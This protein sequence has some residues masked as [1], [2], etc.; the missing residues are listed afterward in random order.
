MGKKIRW[1]ATGVL[2]L[3]FL[4]STGVIL[5]TRHQYRVSEELY[6]RASNRYTVR[7]EELKTQ[8]GDAL[9]PVVVDFDLLRA[10]N[11]DIVG[12]I[13]CEGTPLDYLVVQGPDN[14]YYLRRSY[15]GVHSTAGTIFIDA[16]N[17]PD[18]ADCNTIIYGH[19]MKNGSMFAV[20]SD[21]AEQEFY[22]EHPV[23]W[24]LTPEQDYQ[25]VLKS[26]YTVSAHSDTYTIYP[27]ACEEFD[28]YLADAM[29]RSDFEPVQG[30]KGEGHYVLLSTCSY[31]FDDARYVLLGE[32]VPADSAGGKRI[33]E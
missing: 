2:L 16:S 19:N 23:I 20:L 31:V 6:S 28:S 14:D 29:E 12:W 30:D 22:E 3:V 21:W 32:L 24:I 9:A 4:G 5:Y 15:D 18:F 25:M 33:V 26:G 27:E 10:E 1:I 13:Y 11:E 8:D 17:R 7:M